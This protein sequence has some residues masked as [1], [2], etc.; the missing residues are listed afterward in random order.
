MKFFVLKRKFLVVLLAILVLAGFLRF[1]N[2]GE[3]S[4]SADEFLGVNTAYGYLKTG[5]WRRWDFNLEKPLAD[6]AYF[7]TFFDFDI[8]GDGPDTY[9]RAWIYNWQVAQSLRFL[10]DGET[11]SY[12]VIS[13]LWGIFS[14]LVIYWVAF[15]F[16]KN[17]TIGVI[18]ALLLALSIDGIEFS[19]K[20]RMYAMFMSVFLI[21]SYVAFNFFE[22]KI[23]SKWSS[24]NKLN[25]KTKLNFI[26]LVPVILLGLLSM[27][28]HL[29]A[30]NFV[31]IGLI[32]FLAMG[33]ITYRK[34]KNFKNHYLFYFLV[35]VATGIIVNLKGN[36]LLSSLSWENH[37]SYFEKSFA[38]YGNIL[39]AGALLILGAYYLIKDSTHE[40]VFI[41]INY[42][43]ILLGAMFLWNRNAGEQYIFFAKP[44]QVILM[45]VGIWVAANFFKNN[46]KKY[47]QKVYLVAIIF[48]IVAVIN[49]GYFSARENTYVQTSSSPNPNYRDVFS[50]IMSKR[51]P[52]DILVT[53]NFRNFYWQG[54]QIKVVSLGGERAEESEKKIEL[55]KLMEIVNKN[56]SGWI[57]YS[58]NDAI[59]LSKEA[60]DY[61]DKNLEKIN[62]LKVRGPI[63]VY[64]WN[65]VKPVSRD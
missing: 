34:T 3:K 62:N 1:Y 14:V 32:Y 5:E 20:M 8:W 52:G 26:F 21:F 35:A 18:A 45:A 23:K 12:R 48:L 16:T 17:K 15:K 25:E 39:V 13:V 11:W 58:D 6:N 4:F 27:H 49:W 50:F 54:A 24:I 65:N 63:S 31:F 41:L 40:G 37:F 53:R 64:Y 60:Q 44:F 47:N 56:N 2:L 28:L 36:A 10:P 38:D 42:G 22:S 19:R 9:T 55:E 30:A 57:V 7:K 29:L 46:L 43:F 59:F 33:V 61:I 51:A